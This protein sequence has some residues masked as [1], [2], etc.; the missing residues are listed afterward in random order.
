MNRKQNFQTIAWFFDLYNRK[1]INLDPPYQRRSVW[2][3]PYKDFFIDTL[4]LNYPA[5][6]IFIYEDIS[7]DGS[8]Q[9][10]VVDGKQR[11]TA[12]FDFLKNEFPVFDQAVTSE[13]RGKF[14]EEF[15]KD[16]K[17][18]FYQYTFLVE[19]LPTASE[20]VINGIFDRIN[21]NVAKLTSQELRHARYSGDFITAAEDFSTTLFDDLHSN[22]PRIAGKSQKQMKDVELIAQLLLLI[23]E[24]PKGYSSDELDEA[25]SSRDAEW[26]AKQDVISRYK[27]IVAS[28]SSILK[29]DADNIISKSRLRNQAD[30]YSLFGAINDDIKSNTLLDV[31]VYREKLISFVSML[32]NIGEHE[33]NEDIQLYYQYARVASNR[34][35][36]RKERIR[37]IHDFIHQD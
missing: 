15:S 36:A 21:R 26:E 19:Y 24:G 27:K 8:T 22:F 1:L 34:T 3:Q 28:I 31:N 6:A 5:P 13:L 23:E 12:V 9:Y 4:L 33:N 37:V 7:E 11:L 20:D 25:F 35:T 29:S 32:D 10:N 30:F 18:K 2:N 16:Q 14:F 17:V